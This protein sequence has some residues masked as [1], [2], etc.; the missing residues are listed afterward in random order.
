MAGAMVYSADVLAA[1]DLKNQHTFWLAVGR[2]TTPW[3]DEENPDDEIL[4][5]TDIIE[6]AGYK[7]ADVVSLVKLD[8]GGPIAFNGQNYSL[9]ND[10][11]AFTEGARFL[12]IKASLTH[13]QFPVVAFRQ[14]AVYAD[15]TPNGGHEADDPI[16]PGDVSDNGILIYYRN[17]VVRTRDTD[18]VDIIELVMES[19][20]Q[21]L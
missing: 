6:I 4:T 15:L 7:L 17:H 3:S 2:T 18:I 1:L 21:N 19:Q 13:D 16:L 9:V 8:G 10:V 14:T 12:Y 5:T 20:G 11:D